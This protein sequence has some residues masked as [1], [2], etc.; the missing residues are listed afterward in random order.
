MSGK[1][2]GN[3]QAFTALVDAMREATRGQT[4]REIIEHMLQA[5][6]LV[7]FYKTDK[8][9]KDRLENLDELVNAAEAF[10]TQE[11]FGKNAVALPVDE[12]GG[13]ETIAALEQTPDAETGEIMSPLAAFLTHA[14]LEAGDNQA[15][16]GQDALQLMT[17]HSAKGLEF[18][19]VFITGL[20]EG[21]FPHENSVSDLDGLEEER[22]LMY[23]AITRARKRLYLSFS[24]T[25]MLHG[26]TR[27]NVKS[28]FFDELPEAA[29]KW[30]TPRNQGFGSGY[31]REY[32]AAWARGSGLN[33]IV[34]A[35]RVEP[36]PSSVVQPGGPKTT[37]S[38]GL[39]TGQSVFHTKFGEGVI[40]TLEGAGD[41]ARAQINFGRHG[42]KWLALS[43][44]KL[45]PVN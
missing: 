43:V 34:G 20:E 14:S 22:R 24:Q 44:A 36:R 26:Q 4:L 7:D 3:L 5:S 28:R 35:G 13:A 25:R 30:I 45:T 15:Q 6:G 42:M 38:H 8:E 19:A 31:A 10:V 32:Q 2:G 12:H 16:A 37:S 17:V 21:L 33:S 1:A 27:Y 23:V 40:V 9:G 18:D 41:D 39:R 11:G 29:L